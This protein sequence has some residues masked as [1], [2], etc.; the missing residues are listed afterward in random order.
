MAVTLVAITGTLKKFDGTAWGNARVK[1]RL[2]TDVA[3]DTGVAYPVWSLDFLTE[4]DGTIP[5]G[6]QLAA[7]PSGSWRYWCQ[8]ESNEPFEFPLTADAATLSID[9]L[10]A[11][12]G[13][14][15]SGAAATLLAIGG[16]ASLVWRYPTGNTPPTTAAALQ[17]LAGVDTAVAVGHLC[18]TGN[19]DIYKCTDASNQAALVWVPIG[20]SISGAAAANTVVLRNPDGS[21]I[22]N[23]S[24]ESFAF[25]TPIGV[26]GAATDNVGVYGYSTD[27]IGVVG[28]STNDSGG[29]SSSTNGAYHH[30]FGNQSAIARESGAL[31]FLGASAAANRNAQLTQLFASIP[32]SAGASGTL[33][34]DGGT[35]KKVP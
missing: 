20:L 24:G 13:Q 27:K 2:M 33:W 10:V 18:I 32:T 29:R 19:G 30:E 31:T 3:T 23:L 16:G 12:A 11:L 9:Q 35:I 14:T 25:I 34:N 7:P 6:T 17:G 1:V 21:I 26:L 22:N 28:Q 8:I 5:D 4:S 15:G